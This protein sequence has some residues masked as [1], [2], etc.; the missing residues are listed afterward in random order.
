MGAHLLT[1]LTKQNDIVVALKRPASSTLH[2]EKIFN[3]KLGEESKDLFKR[4][5][6]VDG[7]ILDPWSLSEV[8]QGITEIYHCAAEVDLRDNNP[9]SI[10]TTAEKGTENLVNAALALQVKKICHISS[11]SALG[12]PVEGNITEESFEDFSF[13][14]SPYAIGKHLA[15]QQVWRGYAE[16]LTVVVVSPSIIL[17][18][19]GNL[20]NGSISMFSFID[21]LSK[22][23]TGGIM[24]F[25]DVDDVVNTMLLLMK[26]GPYNERFILNSENISFKDFFTAIADGIHKPVPKNK[27][28]NFTLKVLQAFNNMVSKQKISSTMVEHATGIHNFSNEKIKKATGYNFIP[29]RESIANTAT[30]YLHESSRK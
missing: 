4:I 5:R 17:G 3:L 6:W 12:I 9:G 1:Q 22:F 7:D 25:V 14:N 13:K 30:Y 28:S 24:G 10:I 29:V 19:W 8:M 15:E 2:T 26:N 16:G 23:Y 11:V 20:S 21:K 27:L 18:P